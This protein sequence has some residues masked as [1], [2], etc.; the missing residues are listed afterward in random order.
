[1]TAPDETPGWVSYRLPIFQP[2][3]AVDAMV[4]ALRSALEPLARHDGDPLNVDH[5]TREH[6]AA[7]RAALS[8]LPS[9]RARP[10]IYD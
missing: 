2:A 3:P 10:H 7:A 9:L 8:P 5:I 1:M 4:E 6:V